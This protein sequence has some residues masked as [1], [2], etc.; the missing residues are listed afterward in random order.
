[1]KTL[2]ICAMLLTPPSISE[3]NQHKITE[4]VL[5]DGRT[6]Y[7]L[8]NGFGFED[9]RYIAPIGL[10]SEG[11]REALELYNILHVMYVDENKRKSKTVAKV[12]RRLRMKQFSKKVVNC[13]RRSQ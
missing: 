2:L 4:R 9:I 12:L 6:E 10:E 3:L 1:M 11:Q 7:K 13:L 5:E 8:P